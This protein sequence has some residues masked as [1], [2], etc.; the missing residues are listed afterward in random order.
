MHHTNDLFTIIRKNKF[1][2][3]KNSSNRKCDNNDTIWTGTCSYIEGTFY[4]VIVLSLIVLV[5][6]LKVF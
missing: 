1:N 6:T 2:R 5:V 3:V 4:G